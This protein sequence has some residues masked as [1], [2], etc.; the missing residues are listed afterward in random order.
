MS[1]QGSDVPSEPTAEPEEDWRLTGQE[2]VLADAVLVRKRYRARSETSEH[3][4]C[5]FCWAKFM[6]ADFSPEHR[7][8]IEDNP[9]VL[10]E[11][12]TTTA[13]HPQGAD[14]YWV[15]DACF[16]DFKERFRWRV[17]SG[18]A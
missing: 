17:T 13:E 9:D 3:E 18:D 8:F 10:T 4:H 14:I 7:K 5:E 6:D 16:N 2:D 12:Y 1:E 11:G 15:C